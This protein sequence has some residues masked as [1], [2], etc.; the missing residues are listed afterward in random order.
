MNYY[1]IIYNNNL[2]GVINSYNFFEEINDKLIASNDILGQYIEYENTLYRDYWMQPAYGNRHFLQ[3]S[4]QSISEANY[5]AYIQAKINNQPIN[6]NEPDNNNQTIPEEPIEPE[7]N[8]DSMI[9]YIRSSK[10][11]EMS[12]AC[13]TT[14][15][16]GF[17]LW[18]SDNQYHHFSLTTQDQ[19]NLMAASTQ[20]ETVELIPYHADGE[21]S[22]YYTVDEMRQI[23]A[24]ANQFKTYHTAYYNSLKNY[25]N[26]LSTIEEIAAITYGTKIPEEYQTEVLKTIEQEMISYENH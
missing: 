26:S 3:A 22:K 19:L 9:E 23:I 14:I 2:I 15:E 11:N 10:F 6:E 1:K 7:Y 18:I 20:L 24:A 17:D 13:R 8:S 25:I 4:I 16:N 12:Y 5:N 21:P